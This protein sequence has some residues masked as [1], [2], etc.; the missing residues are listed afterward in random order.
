MPITIFRNE[1]QT[2]SK[3]QIKGLEKSQGWW[4]KLL[5]AD[6]DQDGDEDLLLG[7]HGLN[8]RFKASMEKPISMYV[9]DFDGNGS[10]E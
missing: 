4:N 9:N 1:D 10:V 7:N 2:F 3:I 6:I 5:A 8:S